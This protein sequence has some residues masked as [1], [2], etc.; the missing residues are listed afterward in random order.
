MKMC[1]LQPDKECNNCHQCDDRCELD[2]TKICD[3][4]F[5]CL[6]GDNKE[7]AEILID[8]VYFDEEDVSEDRPL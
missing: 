6:D 3:N 8:G 1:I 4:C 2:P 5:K 7:F